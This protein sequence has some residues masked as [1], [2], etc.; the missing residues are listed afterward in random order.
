[1]KNNNK[2]AIVSASLGVGGAERFAGLLSFMLH[3]LGYEVHHI[4]ILDFVDYDY[5]GTLVNLGKLFSEEKGVFR[6]VK[7]GKHIAKYLHENDI[8]TVIDNRSRPFFIRE[9]FTKWI[10]GNRKSYFMIHSSNL[11]MYF[12]KF[13]FGVNFLYQKA[14]KLVCVSKDIEEKIQEK[15]NLKNTITIHNPVDF[16]DKM[17]QLPNLIPK[18]YILFFGRFEEEIKNF[19]LLLNAFKQ[20]KVYSKGTMLLLVGDGSDKDFIQ[21]KIA[22]LQ[23]EPFVLVLPFQKNITAFIQNAKCTIL[24]SRFEGFPMSLVE[25]L[26]AGTPVI[27]VDCETGPSEIIQ[28]NFN[29]LLVENH[30]EIALSEAIKSM[31]EDE[32][33]HQTCKNNA[34][35]SVE[36]LSLKTIA[37]QW[38]QLLE[39]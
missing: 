34:Q 9:V 28:N 12:S 2:I 5:K 39:A 3:D 31:I 16:P 8:Q 33:L 29:G 7:K 17:Y 14:T 27:S 11:E 38:K 18:S 19:T 13:S 24:T 23:L 25:S 4:I 36:H 15:Y 30:N 6:A 26:A 1:M 22:E 37:Q 21:A 20:S 35:K 10:Y 32:N